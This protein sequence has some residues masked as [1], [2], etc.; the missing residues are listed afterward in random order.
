MAASTFP[1]FY[2]PESAL[3]REREHA[4]TMLPG[5]VLLDYLPAEGLYRT[6]LS[7]PDRSGHALSFPCSSGAS[8]PLDATEQPTGHQLVAVDR[9]ILD[10]HDASGR[11]RVLHC[12]PAELNQGFPN[13][14]CRK[15]GYGVW[16][17][18]RVISYLGGGRV[19]A[20]HR[21]TMNYSVFSSADRGE[22]P[23]RNESHASFFSPLGEGTLLGV[24]N[25][26]QLMHLRLAQGEPGRC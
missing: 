23:L 10:Y 22:F 3:P 17:A 12:P 7:A 9:A 21:G 4:P 14:S 6:W 18:G 26:S 20:W 15:L 11:Y 8:G 13:P 24:H 25:E 2:P 1:W 19:M 5:D 16:P